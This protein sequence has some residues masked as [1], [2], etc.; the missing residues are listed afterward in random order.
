VERIHVTVGA[1][2]YGEPE[3]I[4]AQALDAHG[5]SSVLASEM[6]ELTH[7]LVNTIFRSLGRVP[8]NEV[9]LDRYSV[10]MERLQTCADL[11]EMKQIFEELCEEID[12][13]TAKRRAADDVFAKV[14]NE[15]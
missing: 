11:H 14:A 8:D 5:R 13:S 9:F 1:G 12:G 10:Y 6:L 4:C 3:R 7:D 15:I 2:A